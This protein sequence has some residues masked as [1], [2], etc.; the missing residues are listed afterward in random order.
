MKIFSGI[1]SALSIGAITITPSSGIQYPTKPEEFDFEYST[2]VYYPFEL[3]DKITVAGSFTYKSYVVLTECRQCVKMY[4][5]LYSSTTPYKTTMGAL[6]TL[7]PKTKFTYSYNVSNVKAYLKKGITVEVGIWSLTYSAMLHPVKMTFYEKTHAK[8]DP[9]D[10]KT[11]SYVAKNTINGRGLTYNEYFKFD[12]FRDYID[13]DIYNVLSLKDF[14][15]THS[16]YYP[17]RYGSAYLDILDLNN[18]FPNL[19]ST[20]E[21]YKRIPLT[22]S[23]NGSVVSFNFPDVMYVNPETLEMSLTQISGTTETRNFY[24]PRNKKTL[25][26]SLKMILRVDGLGSNLIRFDYPIEYNSGNN[27]I[28]DCNDSDYCVTGGIR[29]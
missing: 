8:I 10:Y 13:T 24:M 14:T 3:T 28:G 16:F 6:F 29:K 22:L 27:Y 15:F 26:Q 19:Q 11:S 23:K 9:N 5:P 12:N 17:F 4:S 1:L 2:E 20:T 18:A 25:L 21:G 7:T